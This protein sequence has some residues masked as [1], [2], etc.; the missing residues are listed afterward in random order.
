VRCAP[1][2]GILS[3]REFSNSLFT[4]SYPETWQAH[5][6]SRGSAVTLGPRF[7]FVTASDGQQQLAYGAMA[8][9]FNSASLASSDLSDATHRLIGILQSSTP[10]LQMLGAPEQAGSGADL[11]SIVLL[12]GKSPLENGRDISLLVTRFRPEGLFYLLV[13]APESRF[14]EIRP[15]ALNMMRSL[16]F[17]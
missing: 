15:V 11:T 16:R 9:V 7:G 8:G 6:N 12:A 13:I 1:S 4:L 3:Y 5:P 17:Q 2:S 10:D 14:D